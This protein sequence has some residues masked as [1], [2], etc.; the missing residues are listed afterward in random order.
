MNRNIVRSSV[1]VLTFSSLV[2][3]SAAN[4]KVEIAP[5]AGYGFGGDFRVVNTGED[6]NADEG[7]VYGLTV[8]WGA[9]ATQYEFFFS[10]QAT[11]LTGGGDLTPQEA[12]TDLDITYAHIGGLLNFGEGRV[13]PFFGGG[14]GI[15]HFSP[16]DY[17][18]ETRFSMSLGGGAKLFVTKNIGLRFEG[19]GLATLVDSAAWIHSGGGGTQIAIVGDVFWQFQ[20]NAGLIIAF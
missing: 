13:K 12:L 2:T 19:R 9:T 16:R 17:D 11:E 4:P 10:H 1:A 5:F 20:L 8:D 3:A 6:L 14:L 7:S 15:T 18:S